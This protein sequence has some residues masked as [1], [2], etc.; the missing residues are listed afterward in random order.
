MKL[1]AA[2][3]LAVFA[4]TPALAQHAQTSQSMVCR[5]LPNNMYRSAEEPEGREK[6]ISADKYCPVRLSLQGS[7]VKGEELCPDG[8]VAK[9]NFKGIVVSNPAYRGN[10]IVLW[11][12]DTAAEASLWAISF[13]RREVG[14]SYAF[15]AHYTEVGA[16]WLRCEKDP[17]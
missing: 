3:L 17:S 8:V 16:Q 13:E 6:R 9:D 14:V 7:T 1:A 4:A 5:F 10:V 15:L 2:T 12:N 11:A